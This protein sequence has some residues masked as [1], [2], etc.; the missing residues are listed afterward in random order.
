MLTNLQSEDIQE[1]VYEKTAIN[2]L[3]TISSFCDNFQMNVLNTPM[4][5]DAGENL[6]A[7][8]KELLRLL[9][10]CHKTNTV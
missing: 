2:L 4:T 6:V 8:T 1:I 7:A 9:C 3:D 10:A 5:T